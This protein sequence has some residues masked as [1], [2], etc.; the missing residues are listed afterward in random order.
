MDQPCSVKQ[1][2]SHTGMNR[3]GRNNSHYLSVA[4]PLAQKNQEPGI[5]VVCFLHLGKA[6]NDAEKLQKML[7]AGVLE[8]RTPG[9]SLEEGIGG[10]NLYCTEGGRDGENRITVYKYT[11]GT[12]ISERRELVT[13]LEDGNKKEE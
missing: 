1:R 12:G 9:S 4:C 6:Q 11:E 3:E 7:M 10:I 13:V 8:G 2:K 5:F